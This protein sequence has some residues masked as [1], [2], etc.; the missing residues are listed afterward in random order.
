M[1][2]S[3]RTATDISTKTCS[4]H[5][6]HIGYKAYR[7]RPRA[8]SC[9][10]GTSDQDTLSKGLAVA[11]PGEVKVV[12]MN[13]E[14]KGTERITSSSQWC[15]LAQMEWAEEMRDMAKSISAFSGP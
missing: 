10:L 4:S 8:Y 15:I 6:A 1:I 2:K 11:D 13:V 14:A 9:F 12:G 5:W 3:T 7:Q